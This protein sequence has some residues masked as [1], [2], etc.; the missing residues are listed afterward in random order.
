M[1]DVNKNVL[2]VFFGVLAAV[3]LLLMNVWQL[4]LMALLGIAGYLL[5]G[6]ELKERWRAFVRRRG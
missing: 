1:Q 6:L 3:V 2:W 4:A 5:A